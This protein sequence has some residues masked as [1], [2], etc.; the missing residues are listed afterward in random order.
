MLIK[1]GMLKFENQD[2]L[3]KSSSN[4]FGT[5]IEEVK[6]NSKDREWSKSGNVKR[7]WVYH[8]GRK[9]QKREDWICYREDRGRKEALELQKENKTVQRLI[10]NMEHMLREQKECV[11]AFR[12]GYDRKPKNRNNI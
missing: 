8:P 2:W 10:Q 12:E 11:A 3:S 5:K 4:S 7:V 1:A 9:S 6:K